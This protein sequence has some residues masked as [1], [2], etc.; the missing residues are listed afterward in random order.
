MNKVQDARD[1]YYENSI[2][3]G[4]FLARLFKIN[5]VILD[6]VRARW[7]ERL[8]FSNRNGDERH[9]AALCK[10]ANCPEFKVA[11]PATDPPS[12]PTSRVA[13]VRVDDLHLKNKH[14]GTNKNPRKRFILADSPFVI[15]RD[16]CTSSVLL[17]FRPSGINEFAII[18]V[19]ERVV[20]Y[21]CQEVKK[22]T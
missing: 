1:T 15:V 4:A 5:A 9:A 7:S 20:V 3:V 21:F 8:L 10:C 2:G 14:P 12:S 17:Q 19:F 16:A 6:C 11:F 13:I 18:I 22:E